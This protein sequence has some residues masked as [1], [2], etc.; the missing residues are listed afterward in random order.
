MGGTRWPTLGC[1]LVIAPFVLN[2]SG[3]GN[4]VANDRS[5]VE[6]W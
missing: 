2:Y 4:A 1:W 3:V 6:R 5:N